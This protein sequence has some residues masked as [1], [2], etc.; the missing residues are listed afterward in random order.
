MSA[1]QTQDIFASRVLADMQDGVLVVDRSG[2]IITFNAAAQR[3][4]GLGA[5]EVAASSFGEVF[6][7]LE[8]ND[9]F[10]QAILDAVYNASVAEQ[11]VV[12]FSHAGRTVTLS[13]TTSLL[14]TPGEDGQPRTAGVI[15][16]FS[17]ITQVRRLQEAEAAHAQALLA[18]HQALQQAFREA[19]ASHAQLAEAHKKMRAVRLLAAG[20]AAVLVLALAG[21]YL[22]QGRLR[23]VVAPPPDLAAQ[24]GGATP[25][26]VT[27]QPLSSQLT[28]TGRLAPLRTVNVVSPFAGRL[29]Q[30]KVQYGDRV[31]AGQVLAVMDTAEAE[32]KL[33]ETQAALIK[34]EEALRQVQ[35]WDHSA[36]VT[37][38]RRSLTKSKLS[39]EAQKKALDESERLFTQGI[40]PANELESVRQQYTSQQLDHQ[41]AEDELAAAQQRGSPDNLKVVR[42]EL[43]NLRV[44]LRQHEADLAQAV[45]RAAVGGIVMKPPAQVTATKG[46]RSLAAGESFQQGDILLAIG[47][48]QGLQV[49]SRVDEV[50]VTKLRA[51][52]PVRVS[53]DAFAGLTLQGRLRSISP[54][55]E[56]GESRSAP[57]FVIQVVVESLTDA[58]RA[59][60]WVGMSA[61]LEIQVAQREQA[62]LLPL[63]AVTTQDG[64]TWVWKQTG[65][66]AVQRVPVSTGLTTLDAVEVTAGLAAGD[67]VWVGGPPS[68]MAQ[69]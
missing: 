21:A 33:R 12:P 45:V 61:Q 18:Q 25:H 16:V 57:S 50:E 35:Q 1:L 2:Q 10:N 52:Q 56:E 55:A 62:L 32:V 36:D 3:I 4:L 46:S 38:A 34:A 5:D 69:E 67:V 59:R 27:P 60:A 6:L 48:L 14:H 26:T 42:M 66:K 30:L 44:R 23:S 43:E 17:D 49:T 7:T 53:G 15:V 41:S 20:F 8:H 47:D 68:G 65:P 37:R 51:G 24:P 29:A 64:L 11:Q 9:A 58:E 22:W 40:I 39:L 63:A 13:L 31:E 54:Q 19:E 28:L